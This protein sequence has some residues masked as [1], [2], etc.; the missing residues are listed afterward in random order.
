MSTATRRGLYI[1]CGIVAGA[2]APFTVLQQFALAGNSAPVPTNV[3]LSTFTV[4]ANDGF[5][6]F[7]RNPS[8]SLTTSVDKNIVA[9]GSTLNFTYTVLDNGDTG[10][11]DIAVQDDKCTPITGGRAT[12]SPGEK[13]VFTCTTTVTVE[14][15]HAAKVSGTPVLVATPGSPAPQP[16]S[17]TP[18]PDPSASTPASTGGA[19]KDGTYTGA[20]ATVSVPDANESY[21]VQVQA[22]ISG[23]KITEITMPVHT[24]TN[25]TSRSIVK[26][27]VST[28]AALNSDASNPTM[29]YEAITGQ[30]ARI[31]TISG[32]TYTTAGFTSSLADALGQAAA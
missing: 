26:F 14:E 17:T 23:G 20:A 22:V 12:L 6:A 31:A 9:S 10:F 18:A 3:D 25:P 1:A 5:T 32:A 28:N 24:E 21:Q 29:I 8:L 4:T 2:A 16:S 15:T 30:T 13:T 19:L 27:N 7:V 11:K